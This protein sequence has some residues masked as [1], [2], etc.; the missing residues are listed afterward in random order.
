M[1]TTPIDQLRKRRLLVSLGLALASAALGELTGV[2]VAAAQSTEAREL[3]RRHFQR[4]VEL[5]GESAFREALVEF[6]RA[7]E[8]SPHYSVLFNIGQAHVALGHASQAIDAFK[9]YLAEGGANIELDRRRD[10]EAELSRQFE[11]TAT[12][13]VRV[14]RSHAR[15]WVDAEPRG[16]T[17]LS[18]PLRLD[19]GVHRVR[20]ELD[21]GRAEERTLTLAAEEHVVAKFE[22]RDALAAPAQATLPTTPPA[23]PIPR[24][25]PPAPLQRTSPPPKGPSP[26]HTRPWLAYALGGAGVALGGGALAHYLWN[27]GRYHDWQARYAEFEREPSAENRRSA[28]ELADSISRASTVSVGLGAA[29]ALCLGTGVALWLSAPTSGSAALGPS[30]AFVS[31]RGG[32]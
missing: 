22:F 7:Y 1:K 25:S 13:E 3:A 10:V 20:V 11:R 23:L 14:N 4:G 24:P 16:E 32:F 18:E 31:F 2:G 6:T 17:P 26:A 21:A 29:A 28:N 27:R 5:A 8:L 30:S 9:R 19:I 12:L 15:V